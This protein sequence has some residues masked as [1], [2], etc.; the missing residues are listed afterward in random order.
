MGISE[1]GIKMKRLLSVM[2]GGQVRSC[3]VKVRA[4]TF[5]CQDRGIE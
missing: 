3:K 4:V 1:T 5:P 2:P